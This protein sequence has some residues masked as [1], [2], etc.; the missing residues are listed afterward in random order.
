MKRVSRSPFSVLLFMVQWLRRSSATREL[1]VFLAFLAM[2]I[3]MTWPWALHLRDAAHDRLDSYAHSYF[4]WW[5]YHQTFHDPLNLFQANIFYPYHDT[6]AF[7]EN[8]LGI[9]LVCFPLFALGLRPLTVHGLA[10]L[11][12]F[13]FSGYGMFRLARTLSASNIAAWTAGVI[14]AFI[15]YRFGQLDR[16]PLV[17]AGWMPLL[18][19]ALILFVRRRSWGRAVWLG[20]AFFMNGLTCLTWF[21]L[22]LP[23]LVFSAMFLITRHRLWRDKDLWMR[24]AVMLGAT[25]L[26]LAPFMLPFYRV[27]K[28]YGFMRS[29][30]DVTGYAVVHLLN[31]L[32]ISGQNKLWRGLGAGINPTSEL[33]LFPGLLPLLLIFVGIVPAIWAATAATPLWMRGRVASKMGEP[34]KVATSKEVSPAPSKS[35]A[36]NVDAWLLG[37]IWLVTGF[38]G[39][40]GFSLFFHRVLFDYVPLFRAMRV[41]AR[42]SMIC[43]VGL[44]LLAGL[45]AAVCAE[46]LARQRRS[47]KGLI[48]IVIVGAILFEQR[49][50]PLD[51][52][53]GEVD[54]DSLTWRL[55]QTRMIGGIVDLP[56]GTVGAGNQ[57]YMLRAA[58]HERPIVIATNSFMPPIAKEIEELTHSR[59]IPDRLLDLLETIPASYLVVHETF[60]APESRIAMEVFL[61]RG[62][63][64]DR[65]RFIRRYDY[66][67]GDGLVGYNDLY[68]VTKIEPQAKSESELPPAVSYEDYGNRWLNLPPDFRESGFLICRLYQVAFGRLPRFS[69]FMS[70]A[71]A[72][73]GQDGGRDARAPSGDLQSIFDEFSHQSE[74][75]AIYD[76][77]SN[78]RYVDALLAHAEINPAGL[79]RAA[80]VSG[81]NKGKE[82]RAT[83]LRSIADNESFLLQ[84]LDSAF[85]LMNYFAYLERDPD[86]GGYDFWL[87]KLDDSGNFEEVS[88]SFRSSYEHELIEARGRR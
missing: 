87:G 53:H 52:I 34:L 41:P 65:L 81:L 82:T 57:R 6:F 42:W 70:Y 86:P 75:K 49:A 85:V 56:A 77:Q 39:S 26:T 47:W 24:A 32:A 84:E 67:E 31:W 72:H 69:E 66:R 29:K 20:V 1:L 62:R 50:A 58:D 78:D 33:A 44:A 21:A 8:D 12:G 63:S 27:S 18:L 76:G 10:T 2:T 46:L 7:G 83:V 40:F 43:Y 19:E 45:S 5:G 71:R 48:G 3:A 80:L 88:K 37:S 73:S 25:A 79:D 38:L 61:T 54:S 30:E 4:L 9:S 74:F 14:F 13:A 17:F 60:L 59:P 15:P 28:V 51:L 23:P 22:T 16:L 55:K 64:A 36:F 35:F 68:A 11:I